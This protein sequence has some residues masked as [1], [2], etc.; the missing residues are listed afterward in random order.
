M[1]VGQ[2]IVQAAASSPFFFGSL[3]IYGV[4]GGECFY[5]FL[6]AVSSFGCGCLLCGCG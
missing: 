5:V 2:S 3:M 6:L 1:F 4:G